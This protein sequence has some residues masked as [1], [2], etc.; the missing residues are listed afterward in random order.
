M[1]GLWLFPF[2]SIF[3]A[4]DSIRIHSAPIKEVNAFRTQYFPIY[5]AAR[6]ELFLTVRKGVK[7]DEEIF[8]AAWNGEKFE[9]PR[10]IEELNQENNEGTPT[11][12]KD[13]LHL[14]FSGCDY[15]NS[16]GGCDLYECTWV[17][18]SWTRPKNLGYLVNSH[19]W[20]GQPQLNS[21]GSKLF[22]SSDRPGGEGKRDIW[23][24]ERT[25]DGKWGIP[26][27]LG[28]QINSPEDE[29]GPYFM[30]ERGILVFSTNQKGG[31]G[32][33][34][35]HQSLWDEKVWSASVAI[36]EI[37]SPSN[38]A[39][40]TEGINPN[41]YFISRKVV[42]EVQDIQIQSIEIPEFCWLKKPPIIPAPILIAKL[43]PIEFQKLHF[44]DIQFENNKSDL[45]FVTPQCL[46]DLVS[47]LFQNPSK[48][49]EIHG[50]TDEVGNAQANL[51]LSDR[52]ANSVKTYLV[53]QGISGDRIKTI[54]FGN[55]KPKIKAVTAEARKINRRIEIIL[56]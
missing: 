45:P 4:G 13:G 27:N 44:E 46:L 25:E 54:A 52:R 48:S 38:D 17:D 47:Y 19:D 21:N 23:F 8:V 20:E 14:I 29:Q 22:F 56:P 37:N 7:S 43:G 30:D 51:S 50:H 41:S 15:P 33:L 3:S 9:S 28:K 1:I 10:P 5:S 35:F 16:F 26:K 49:I 34:D 18:G 36:K 39:G 40:F 2:L 42:D 12:S 53:D 24:T 31:Q 6:K 55:S 32:G 11:L